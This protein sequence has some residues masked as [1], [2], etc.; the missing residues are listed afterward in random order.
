[1]ALIKVSKIMLGNTDDSY[2]R[3][4]VSNSSFSSFELNPC[5]Y[6]K[7]SID[8]YTCPYGDIELDELYDFIIKAANNISTNDGLPV[9]TNPNLDIYFFA[10]DVTVCRGQITKEDVTFPYENQ[11]G[12]IHFE[13]YLYHDTNPMTTRIVRKDLR[14]DNTNI[15]CVATGT[16]L[17][18]ANRK[19]FGI[20]MSPADAIAVSARHEIP[21]IDRII[22]NNPATIVYWTDGTKTVV[23]AHNEEFSEEH[24]LAMAFA[25]KV[26]ETSYGSKHP[27]ACFKRL[28][29]E[30]KHC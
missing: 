10:S 19:M 21:G 26:L 28:V 11:P 30:A 29:R 15:K 9:Y 16:Q 7:L 3:I 8:I 4:W 2:K 13:Y 6:K 1:M 5:S 27:R 17:Q 25:R 14:M 24:G 22:F 23:K 20:K 18:E 12:T